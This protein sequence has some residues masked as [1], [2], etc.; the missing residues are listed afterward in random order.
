[1]LAR[2][3]ALP[4]F[5]APATERVA[6]RKRYFWAVGHFYRRHTFEHRCVYALEVAFVAA[7]LALLV[8]TAR[9]LKCA[10]VQRCLRG[11]GGASRRTG[12]MDHASDPRPRQG[13]Y[14]YSYFV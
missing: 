3:T 1:M 2:V 11:L 4:Y 13:I 6:A 5:Q 14:I 8:A 10:N 7:E 9:H 12:S